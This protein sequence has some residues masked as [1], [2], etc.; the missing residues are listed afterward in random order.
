MEKFLT[1]VH[2]HSTFSAD[3]V[4]ENDEPQIA[5]GLGGNDIRYRKIKHICNKKSVLCS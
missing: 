5:E 2:N 1:D 3:G 4:S